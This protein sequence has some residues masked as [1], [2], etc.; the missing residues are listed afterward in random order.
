MAIVCSPYFLLFTQHVESLACLS[1]LYEESSR[2]FPIGP[3]HPKSHLSCFLSI[4]YLAVT[5]HPI[6]GISSGQHAM[7]CSQGVCLHH[8]FTLLFHARRFCA[9]RRSCQQF[10]ILTLREMLRRRRVSY[11]LRD[12]IRSRSFG[13][14]TGILNGRVGP[15]QNTSTANRVG[16][17]HIF[18]K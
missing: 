16:L 12:V 3:T 1:S 15:T 7:L 4:P 17:Q 8:P 14:G 2:T 10:F 13:H 11:A 6:S 18:L 9:K 5:A